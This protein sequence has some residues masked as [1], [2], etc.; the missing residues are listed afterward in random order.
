VYD[1]LEMSSLAHSLVTWAEFL[2]LPE[3]PEDGQHY[4]LQDGE[5]VVVPPP[6]PRHVKVQTQLDYL[7]REL[8]GDSGII[9]VEFPYRP[10][11][12]LQFWYADVAYI[13]KSD[14]DAMPDNYEVYAPPLIIEVLSPSNRPAKINRQRMVALSAGTQEFWVVD[15]DSRTVH[16]TSLSAARTYVA[17]ESISSPLFAGSIPVDAIR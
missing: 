7:L 1:E 2:E 9:R 13:P 8:V 11:L 15:L 17:G 3:R 5:V 6:R 14:W 16:V 12:N 10:A 4:E